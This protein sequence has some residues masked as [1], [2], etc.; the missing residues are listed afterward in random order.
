[1]TQ[2]F[3]VF[4]DLHLSKRLSKQSWRQWFE[5]HSCT[6]WRHCNGFM[7]CCAWLKLG[8]TDVPNTNQNYCTATW[9]IIAAKW[10][11]RI[12]LNKSYQSITKD[13]V[14]SWHRG[15]MLLL[16]WPMMTCQVAGSISPIQAQFQP[17]MSCL[18]GYMESPT[19]GSTLLW[20][21]YWGPE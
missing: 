4:F 21:D 6:L 18:H 7:L 17:I 5:T 10:F 9:V 11:W 19:S 16:F 15:H 20:L 1:M 13:N 3:D 8:T 12:W 14:I 2:S